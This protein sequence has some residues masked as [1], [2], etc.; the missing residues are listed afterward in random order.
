MG[1]AAADE[2]TE[3]LG[4]TAIKIPTAFLIDVCGLKGINVGVVRRYEKYSLIVVNATCNATAHDVMRL[5]KL[6]RQ[7]VFQKT[8]VVIVPKLHFV[9]FTSEELPGYFEL[10]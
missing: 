10:D 9:G 7:T 6:V 4:V 1:T 2:L 5:M 8:G 3:I